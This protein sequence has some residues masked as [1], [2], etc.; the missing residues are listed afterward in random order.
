M[1]LVGL[2]NGVESLWFCWS[3]AYAGEAN[4]LKMRPRPKDDALEDFGWFWVRMEWAHGTCWVSASILV[5]PWFFPAF[6]PGRT[7][8]TDVESWQPSNFERLYF[9]FLLEL[10]MQQPRMWLAMVMNGAVLTVMLSD[11]AWLGNQTDTV[12]L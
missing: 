8:C 11:I 1:H 2:C 6:G 4:I 5:V 3:F 7:D 10:P 12:S 9:F